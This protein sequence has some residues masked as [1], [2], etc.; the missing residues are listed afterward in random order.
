MNS[1]SDVKI[2]KVVVVPTSTREA[3]PY[4]E[5]L[6]VSDLGKT[7]NKHFGRLV[8]TDHIISVC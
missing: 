7:I 3:E 4:R 6:E 8:S 1:S 5:L 2:H